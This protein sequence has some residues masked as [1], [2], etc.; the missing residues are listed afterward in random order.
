MRSPR[1]LVLA[2]V[3]AALLG[4]PRPASADITAFLGVSPTTATRM[5]R[6]VAVGA[7]FLVVGFEFEYSDIVEDLGAGAP[8]LRTGTFN[9]LLQTPIAVAGM[10]FYATAGAGVYREELGVASETHVALNVGGGIKLQLIG[11]LR[12]RFDYRLFKLRGSPINNQYHRFYAGLN[13]GF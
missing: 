2:A 13:L 8:G 10:R 1:L 3:L 6:G 11:P 4:S 9:G 7:T 5:A 12:A